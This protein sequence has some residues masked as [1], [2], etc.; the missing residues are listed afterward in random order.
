MSFLTILSYVAVGLVVLVLIAGLYN[1]LRGGSPNL[2]QK[3]MRARIVLQLIAIIIVLA[4]LYFS[5]RNGGPPLPP[6]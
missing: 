2:S 6:G 5:T 4:I 3:L 1:L